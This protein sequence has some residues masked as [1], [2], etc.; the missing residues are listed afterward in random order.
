MSAPIEYPS[1]MRAA[2]S[3]SG[4]AQR[5][6]L[7]LNVAQLIILVVTA[8]VTGWTPPSP[9]AQR[10]VAV[11]VALMMFV[12]LGVATVLRLNKFDERWFRCRALAENVKSAVWYFVM[13]G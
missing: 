13:S 2:D 4:A 6:F 1:L 11:A 10:W 3:A 7:R 5:G 9:D 8:L 12:A